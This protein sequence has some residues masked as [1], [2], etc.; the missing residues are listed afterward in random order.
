MQPK[1]IVTYIVLF[2]FTLFTRFWLLDRL[3]VSLV[4]DETVYAAHA[5]SFAV[6]G[7]T[8]NQAISWWSLQPVHPFYAELPSVVMAPAF[9]FSDSPL[10]ASH[11][12][13][14]V[15][16][17]LLP[18]IVAW[19]SYGIWR[20]KRL[21]V[22]TAFV[23]AT[24]PL[25]WQF[26]RLSY[27]AIFSTFFYILGA[28]LL[29]NTKR[30]WRLLSIPVFIV[31]F[32]QYQ[33]LKLVLVPFVF[34]IVGLYLLEKY[35]PNKSSQATNTVLGF[36]K[37]WQTFIQK[38]VNRKMVGLWLVAAFSL[39]LTLF[40]GLYML[41]NQDLS[42]RTDFL[43]F[44]SDT[45]AESV[46][47]QRRQSIQ[48]PVTSVS[49]NKLWSIFDFMLTRASHAFNPDIL[50]VRGET[51][52]S[53]FAVTTHGLFYLID[54]LLI[55]TAIYV[56]SQTYRK[57]WQ[58]ALFFCLVIM[59]GLPTYINTQ[60]EWHLLRTQLAYTMLIFPISWGL[61]WFSQ[62][63]WLFVPILLIYLLSVLNF[64]YHYFFRYPITSADRANI[65]ER[66]IARYTTLAKE[67]DP[68]QEIFI[69]SQ[70][71]QMLFFN[72]LLFTNQ[73]NK[74]TVNE[75]AKQLSQPRQKQHVDS[76]TLNNVTFTN[77]CVPA[78]YEDGTVHI[79]DQH[80]PT[81]VEEMPE[82][83]AESELEKATLPQIISVPSVL[84]SGERYRIT[85]DSTCD[86]SLMTPF[87]QIKNFD[88]FG[89]EK[90]SANDLCHHWLSDLTQVK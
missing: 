63:R 23:A 68:N 33:G 30:W 60:S 10:L 9:W 65:A 72:H 50:F 90:M 14:A 44:K 32:F 64:S 27:D 13:S 25:L 12:T 40:Y 21:S 28:A 67:N 46:N 76:F 52:I 41:P 49:S 43:I 8:L 42:N 83:E 7:T 59:L 79:T 77:D 17:L 18:F 34:G 89:I 56:F 47:L 69:Y 74:E 86:T 5:K 22:L 24:N 81:C 3:P 78:V 75:I 55:G 29:V 16:G 2:V 4:H 54:I 80:F 51:P 45:L 58:M 88:Q 87:V 66:V 85:G 1:Y 15:M 82:A 39:V 73:I 6:Q 31:G 70:A 26:S 48:S 62:R 57:K 84:D 53:L 36:I 11:A 35:L 71:P 61:W 37:S 38:S 19:L 20:S